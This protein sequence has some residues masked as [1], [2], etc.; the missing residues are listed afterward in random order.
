MRRCPESG[1]R[2]GSERGKS[3]SVSKGEIGEGRPSGENSN[4]LHDVDEE[5]AERVDGFLGEEEFF[6]GAKEEE[7]EAEERGEVRRGITHLLKNL[8]K[9]VSGETKGKSRMVD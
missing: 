1:S 5:H 4:G 2:S 3:L 9:N 6:S 8:K 7:D